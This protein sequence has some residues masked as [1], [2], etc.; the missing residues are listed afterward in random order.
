MLSIL[1]L[2]RGPLLWS[3]VDWFFIYFYIW[4]VFF[5]RVCCFEGNEMRELLNMCKGLNAFFFFVHPFGLKSQCDFKISL[6]FETSCFSW[7]TLK[8]ISL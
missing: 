2:V 3:H 7:H 4:V 8:I 5:S 6:V 1:G